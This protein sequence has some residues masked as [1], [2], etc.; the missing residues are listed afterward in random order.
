MKKFKAFFALL[1]AFICFVSAVPTAVANDAY[2][3]NIMGEVKTASRGDTVIYQIKASQKGRIY[4]ASIHVEWAYDTTA[5]TLWNVE[6]GN[7]YFAQFEEY[8]PA[9]ITPAPR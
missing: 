5:L 9:S 8:F 1:M 2:A 7:L 3:L 6:P 4:P